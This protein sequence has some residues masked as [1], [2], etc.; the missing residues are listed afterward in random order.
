MRPATLTK[1]TRVFWAL[2]A[3]NLFWAVLIGARDGISV[4]ITMTVLFWFT[5]AIGAA[6]ADGWHHSNV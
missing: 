1:P 3:A 6:L 4:A 5:A 2:L